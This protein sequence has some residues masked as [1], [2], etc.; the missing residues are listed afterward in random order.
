MML[1]IF[2]PYFPFKQTE[3]PMLSGAYYK[4]KLDGRSLE[5]KIQTIFQHFKRFVVCNNDSAVYFLK[6]LSYIGSSF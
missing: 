6:N 3:T 4:S 5:T 1:F 2:E